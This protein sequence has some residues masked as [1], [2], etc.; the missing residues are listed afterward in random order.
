[1]SFT[2]EGIAMIRVSC[3]RCHSVV[4]G[5]DAAAGQVLPCPKCRTQLQVPASAFPTATPVAP[6]AP[7]TPLVRMTAGEWVQFLAGTEPATRVPFWIAVAAFLSL[8]LPCLAAHFLASSSPRFG[9]GELKNYDIVLD[10]DGIP[11][12]LTKEDI[13]YMIAVRR[14]CLV[15][16]GATLLLSMVLT[17]T[18]LCLWNRQM[19]AGRIISVGTA[20]FL[21]PCVCLGY[22]W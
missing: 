11:R 7:S 17:T 5:P 12:Q 15:A 1:L 3:P 6:P 9:G 10:E 18:S 22:Y 19:L 8:L 16:F 2:Y 14:I 21:L 20:A 4:S 13:R